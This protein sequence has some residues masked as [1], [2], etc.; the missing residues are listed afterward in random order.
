MRQ[1]GRAKLANTT[2]RESN[3]AP[4]TAPERRASAS[5]GDATSKSPEKPG[6]MNDEEVT[7][8]QEES[9][10]HTSWTRGTRRFRSVRTPTA[11]NARMANVRAALLGRAK[12]LEHCPKCGGELLERLER[13]QRWTGGFATKTAAQEALDDVKQS[14]RQGTYVKPTKIM[15]GEYLSDPWLPAMEGKVKPSTFLSYQTHVDR[16]IKPVL[17]GILLKDLTVEALDSFYSQLRT[18]PRRPTEQLKRAKPEEKNQKASE[19]A[20]KSESEPLP[21]CRHSPSGRST[22]PCTKDCPDAVRW[23]KLARNPASSADPPKTKSGDHREMR[24]STA[25][26]LSAFLT[27]TK[28]T[29]HYPLWITLA[30]TG[31]RRGEAMGLRWKDV[32]FDNARISVRQNRVSVNYDVKIGTPKAGEAATSPSTRLPSPS[33]NRSRSSRRPKNCDGNALGTSKVATYSGG[34][35]GNHIIRT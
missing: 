30:A 26:Q 17:G 11:G 27:S 23:N 10:G 22:P 13:R 7:S 19:A 33:S 1:R 6:V 34:T 15:V 8:G 28:G 18:Q 31:M 29:R 2:S 5:Y 9:P 16:H 3:T 20:D 32:D 4:T 12:P 14:L 21:P 35:T 24:T 25:G